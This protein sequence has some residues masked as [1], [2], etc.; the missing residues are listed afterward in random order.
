MQLLR[1][2]QM[3]T[4]ELRLE[5]DEFRLATECQPVMLRHLA[6]RSGRDCSQLARAISHQ[7]ESVD[8]N[9]CSDKIDLEHDC[10]VNLT[11]PCS[12]A[13]DEAEDQRKF[14][15]FLRHPIAPSNSVGSAEALNL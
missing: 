6:S 11:A 3:S 9:S 13:A 4:F 14:F 10:A 12:S 7:P 5:A 15:L 8:G 1:R 2:H